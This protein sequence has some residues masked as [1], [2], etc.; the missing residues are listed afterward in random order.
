MTDCPDGTTRDALP[1]FVQGR[2]DAPAVARVAAHLATCASCADEVR[3]LRAV[4]G[5][6][7]TTTPAL[8][9]ARLVAALPAPPRQV[10]R[11]IEVAAGGASRG[12]GASRRGRASVAGAWHWSSWRVAASVAVIGIGGL[13]VA[14]MQRAGAPTPT[15]VVAGPS[16]VAAT[17]V[18][19]V[20]DRPSVARTP[21]APVAAPSATASA[22]AAEA[23][24]LPAGGGMTDLA[25]E[26]V[27]SLLH[28]IDSFDGVPDANPQPAVAVPH[29]GG[30]L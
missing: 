24:A 13:S 8:D 23:A 20:A 5:A 7:M 6:T 11:P 1:D 14:L 28:D 3:L 15:G 12:R 16:V 18:A 4:L 29:A 2:L 9:R 21:A 27:E 10:V 19:G 25:D 30:V 17:P 22:D 26:E